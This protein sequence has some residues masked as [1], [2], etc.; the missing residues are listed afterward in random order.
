MLHKSQI[1]INLKLLINSRLWIFEYKY[2]LT[3]LMMELFINIDNR[4]IQHQYSINW[5][6]KTRSTLS[7]IDYISIIVRFIMTLQWRHN[8]RDGVP[9]HR[10]L[11]CL[12]NRLFR[13]RSKKKSKL[14]VTGLCEGNPRETGGFPSQ[15]PVTG[16]M[17]SFGDVIMNDVMYTCLV[18]IN[19]SNRC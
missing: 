6:H 10:R 5:Y 1:S 16:E 17:F 11:D 4:I 2:E 8:E 3:L 12:L 19:M 7:M 15:R 18:S 9:N 14:R 13:R